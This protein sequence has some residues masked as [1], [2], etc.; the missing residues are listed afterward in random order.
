MRLRT[1][2]TAAVSILVGGAPFLH[3]TD[4]HAALNF[5]AAASAEVVHLTWITKDAPVSETIFDG[6]S[7]S[8]RALLDAIGNS[9]ATAAA[10]NPGDQVTALPGTARGLEPQLSA[11]P[12][13]PYF[14]VSR[15]P[16][17][18][19]SSQDVGPYELEAV[20]ATDRSTASAGGETVKQSG[21][22]LAKASSLADTSTD[23]NKVT[24]RATTQASG[25]SVAAVEIGVVQSVAELVADGTGHHPTAQLL[26]TGLS[27]AGVPL[28]IGP[29]G[30]SLAG[31]SSPL[32][33]DSPIAQFLTAQGIGLHYLAP[34]I[35]PDTVLSPGLEITT[36]YQPPAGAPFG[37]TTQNLTLGRSYVTLTSSGS[38]ASTDAGSF[39]A[40]TPTVNQPAVTGS[41]VLPTTD[42]P[43]T[44][45][46]PLTQPPTDYPST[47]IPTVAFGPPV[48]VQPAA[49][50]A[51]TGDL[52][53]D[54]FPPFMVAGLGVLLLS[55]LL[56]IRGVRGS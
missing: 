14:A 26:V 53:R 18:P 8:A 13:Y 22:L 34:I 7:P 32:P 30:L 27:V 46:I 38:A 47:T 37:L 42:A 16:T 40:L 49:L 51:R 25:I 56:R 52:H 31:Q 10:S 3:P 54:L 29:N 11:L 45:A 9:T 4:A 1:I 35:T 55:Q 48:R 41:G 43:L 6:G 23:G 12:D 24:S 50:A 36:R 2:G 33:H 17:T 20:S 5:S 39:P 44:A 19:S 21:L 28:S 15:A